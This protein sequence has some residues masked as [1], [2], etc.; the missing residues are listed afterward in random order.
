M[1]VD[2]A[3]I[4]Q[5]CAALKIA[6]TADFAAAGVSRHELAVAVRDSVVL[7]VREGVFIPTDALAEVRTAAAH[8]GV[9]GCI[10]RLRLAGVWLLDDDGTSVHVVLPRNG[11]RHRSHDECSCVMHWTGAAVRGDR[12]SVVD[13]LGCLLAC[14]GEESFFVALES[15]LRKRIVTKTGLARLRDLIPSKWRWLVD[16]ARWDADSGLESLLRLRLRALGI[17]L[18]CQVEIPGVGRVDFMLGDRLILEVDGRLNHDG[19]SMRH[20]DLVRDAVAAAL[21]LDTL[22]FDYAMV[23]HEWPLVEA[24]I[25][26]RIDRG[27]HLDRRVGGRSR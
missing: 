23:V 8:G 19:V 22:R 5:L 10:S 4:Q 9:V 14:R 13:A 27:L 15:A 18:A 1:P 2:L 24:A 12:T 21:G 26:A 16:F 3:R 20:K 6:R 25:L 7:R 17:A 11:H